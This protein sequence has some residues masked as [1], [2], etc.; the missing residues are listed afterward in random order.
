MS[1]NN[2]EP[3]D[4]AQDGLSVLVVDDSPDVRVL[5]GMVIRRHSPG[6]RVAGLAESGGQAVELARL[7]QPDV[8][9]LDISMP[10]MDGV[11]ALPLVHEAA[12]GAVVVMLTGFTNAEARARAEAA[13]ADGFVVKDN[14][15]HALVPRV[16]E[17]LASVHRVPAPPGQSGGLGEA[18]SAR[19][20]R[21]LRH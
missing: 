12:P 2:P 11:E 16:E 15:V 20:I 13:G 18:P 9:L 17:V 4:S 19:R 6:W 8:V 10:G 21:D 1:Q 14:L 7:A 3:T 5:I